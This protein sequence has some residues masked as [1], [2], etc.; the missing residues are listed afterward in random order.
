[1]RPF[2]GYV[3]GGV[4]GVD[5]RVVVFRP[6]AAFDFQHFLFDLFQGGDEAVEFGFALALGRLDHQ[7]AGNGEG[8]GRGVEAVVHQ[9]FGDVVYPYQKAIEKRLLFFFLMFHQMETLLTQSIIP[10]LGLKPLF[11]SLA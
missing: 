2:A 6:F 8:D 4:R 3:G 5:Q 9:A 10:G 1:M 11:S 7:R